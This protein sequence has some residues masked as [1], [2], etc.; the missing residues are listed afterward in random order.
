MVGAAV[1][2]GRPCYPLFID[3][4][5]D[6]VDY[7]QV[8]NLFSRHGRLKN[9]FI[10][11]NRRSRRKFYIGFVRYAKKEDV[12]RALELLDGVRLGGAYLS[13][14]PEIFAGKVG[15]SRR[16]YRAPGEALALANGPIAQGGAVCFERPFS[17]IS[18]LER[19]GEGR[20][21]GETC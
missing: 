16:S 11:R 6:S 3:G 7:F 4:I 10:Q 21:V 5:A 18:F 17:S 14:K 19:C 20:F 12:V 1:F 15:S 8:R 13:V 2:S 9:V